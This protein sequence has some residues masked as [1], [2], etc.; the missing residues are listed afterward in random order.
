MKFGGT[1]NDSAVIELRQKL[2]SVL[3]E[4]CDIFGNYNSFGGWW[5]QKQNDGLVYEVV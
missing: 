4:L 2:N 3:V 5:Q 1:W